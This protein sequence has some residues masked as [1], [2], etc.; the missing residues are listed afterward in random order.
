LG[1]RLSASGAGLVLKISRFYESDLLILVLYLSLVM[2]F[3]VGIGLLVPK[4][5]TTPE[6]LHWNKEYTYPQ[7]PHIA[8]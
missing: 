3:V 6:S 7:H 4:V 1:S 8:A 2:L 5:V